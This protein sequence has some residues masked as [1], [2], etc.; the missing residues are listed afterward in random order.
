MIA[1]VSSA[2]G[3]RA[4]SATSLPVPGLSRKQKKQALSSVSVRAPTQERQKSQAQEQ[5]TQ[6]PQSPDSL[7][8]PEPQKYRGASLATSLCG[9]H[10]KGRSISS[11]RRQMASTI[12]ACLVLGAEGMHLAICPSRILLTRTRQQ[13]LKTW[14]STKTPR[15]DS[16][17]CIG[18]DVDASLC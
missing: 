2:R 16:R 3:G 17:G 6:V 18:R 14:H 7:E 1:S 12:V 4:G 10:R 8:H 9:V 5:V 11:S 15:L 13:E